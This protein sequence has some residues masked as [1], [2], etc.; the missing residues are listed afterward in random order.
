M[1]AYTP[2]P[3]HGID[4]AIGIRRTRLPFL[5]LAIGMGGCLF[6][7]LLQW[8]TNAA[9]W[10]PI[11]PGYDFKIGGKPLWSLPANIPPTFEIIVLS[12]AFAAFFGMLALNRLPMFANPL[13]RIS[14]FKRATNDRFFLM[15]DADDSQFDAQ[16]TLGDLENW[17]GTDIEECRRDLTDTQLPAFVR[18]V[19]I[20]LAVLLLIPPVL[21]YRA[22]GMVN[23]TPRLHVVPDMD[24]QVRFDAQYVGPDLRDDDKAPHEW[25]FDDIRAMRPPIEGTIARGQ[26]EDDSEMYRGIRRG[27]KIPVAGLNPPARLAS[28]LTQEDTTQDD[29]AQDGAAAPN[30][31][32]PQAQVPEPEWVTEF[33]SQLTINEQTLLRGQKLYNIYCSACHGYSGE[34]DGCEGVRDYGSQEGDAGLDGEGGVDEGS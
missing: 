18:T 8:Y 17:G 30:A 34:G 16:R 32:D 19:G 25:L 29:G 10:S 6:G 4:A 21:I 27:S 22:R 9:A 7:V 11:F 5:V 28:A 20:L 2:F 23:R 13:H 12:S 3:V 15:I 24:F 31:A 26:L 1:D 33:P 14:R